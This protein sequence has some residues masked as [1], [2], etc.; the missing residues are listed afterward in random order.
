MADEKLQAPDKELNLDSDDNT[1]FEELG[2]DIDQINQEVSQISPQKVE[3]DTTGL[4]LDFEEEIEP[5]AEAP[6]PELEPE[7]EEEPKQP[8]A[9]RPGWF[10][11]VVMGGS[12]VLL[13]LLVVVVGYFTWWA[14]ED[15]KPPVPGAEEKKQVQ[16]VKEL[17]QG[18]P[19]LG[20]DEF[21]VPL[22]SAEKTVLRIS[23]HLALNSESAK[24]LLEGQKTKVRD[25]IYKALLELAQGDLKT[26]EQ[27]LALREELITRLNR[28]FTGSP[29]QEIYFTEFFIL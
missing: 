28:T 9:G 17:P 4:D 6:E 2:I 13:A 21:S 19:L 23:I 15:E 1:P 14:P 8:K 11:P 12:G 22:N 29:V 18:V 26:E 10:W 16:I 5:A 24:T 20:L 3:L 25:T 7:K 27:R